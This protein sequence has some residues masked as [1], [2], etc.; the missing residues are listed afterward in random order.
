M[1]EDTVRRART[2]ALA[3]HGAD[4]AAEPSAGTGGH[5]TKEAAPPRA[6]GRRE[7]G[8]EERRHR[9]IQAAR[10][11]IRETGRTGLSM[12]ALA[13][14]AGVSLATPYNLFGSRGAVVLAVLE[15]VRDFQARFAQVRNG[16]PVDHIL[17]VVDLAVEFYLGDPA[18]YT[19]LWREVFSV[20]GEVRTA[21][22]NPRRD[23]FWLGLVN[24]I[25]AA[26]ALREEI[27]TALLLRQLDHQFRS[28][29]LDWVA[30]DLSAG[31]L[32]PTIKLGYALILCGAASD[33]ARERIAHRVAESQR[34]LREAGERAAGATP[35]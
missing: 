12:R 3:D 4:L 23:E 34:L 7:A 22:Y 18:F 2:G 13:E 17:A 6:R 14:R 11:M 25:A 26:G 16:D 1:G 32:G 27:D 10:E 8:K 31:L 5:T 29:M 19:T 24:D 33:E 20:S 30:G 28:V 35:S 21:I 9:I 15:D